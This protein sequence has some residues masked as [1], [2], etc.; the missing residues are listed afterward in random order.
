MNFI[1]YFLVNR[2]VFNFIVESQPSNCA[3]VQHIVGGNKDGVYTI[4][5]SGVPLSVYCDLTTDGGGWTV[6]KHVYL[7]L[8]MLTIISINEKELFKFKGYA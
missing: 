7:V 8:C 3:Q 4:Y 5:P 2:K 1:D 6:R